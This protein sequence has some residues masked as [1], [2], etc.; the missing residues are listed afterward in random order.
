MLYFLPL[1]FSTARDRCADEDQVLKEMVRRAQEIGETF[2]EVGEEALI[3]RATR[4]LRGKLSISVHYVLPYGARRFIMTKQMLRN[5]TSRGV[6]VGR[7][8]APTNGE[9]DES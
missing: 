3:A 6:V 4:R 2:T 1:A 9:Y 5:P 7:S 8:S